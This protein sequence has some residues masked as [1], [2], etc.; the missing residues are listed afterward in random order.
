MN[1][2][3]ASSLSH[4]PFPCQPN[5]DV[6]KRI[7]QINQISSCQ[8]KPSAGGET[9]CNQLYTVCVCLCV[10]PSC[11]VRSK[12]KLPEAWGLE[13]WGGGP[14]GWRLEAAANIYHI[15]HTHNVTDTFPR[16]AMMSQADSCRKLLASS[17]PHFSSNGFLSLLHPPHTPDICLPRILPSSM[18]T[19]LW[20]SLSSSPP[21]SQPSLRFYHFNGGCARS[22]KGQRKRWKGENETHKKLKPVWSHVRHLFPGDI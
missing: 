6:L 4:S 10:S 13:K 9:W 21:S 16:T 7:F 18:C 14:V 1:Q 19:S 11:T 12:E 5:L 22:V 17:Q 2:T 15:M 3:E 8:E 20:C